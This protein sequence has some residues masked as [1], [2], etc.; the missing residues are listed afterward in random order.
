MHSHAHGG[1]CDHHG[2]PRT[3]AEGTAGGGTVDRARERRRLILTLG[4]TIVI[5]VAEILG[6]LWSHSLALLSDAGHMLSDV[7]AQ[8]L[9]LGA[10]Y[11]AARPADERRTYGWYRIEILAALMNGVALVA[12]SA[13]ILWV[14]AH[15]LPTPVEVQTAL[16]IKIAAVGL[17]ANLIGAWL[18]HDLESLNMRGAY[19]HIL[20]DSL[21]S[22][23]VVVGGLIMWRSRG[24]Y[25]LDPVLSLL[26]GVFVLYSAYR[27]IREAVDVLLEAVPRGID[28]AG[29]THA[30]DHIEGVSGVHD[31]HIWTITSG[32][33]A[34]SAH[35]VVTP[36]HTA[37]HDQLLNRVKEMLLRDF[38]IAHTTLQ[39]ESE[40][41]EH[42]GHVC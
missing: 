37:E 36:G 32:L 17:V 6:G 41:Y 34:L 1:G 39:I 42:V 8:G 18:L 38:A 16:M 28:L 27:L 4:V 23:A 33:H 2:S 26:I 13:G 10:L 7:V 21:S 15:R 22:A 19:L 29:V 3:S 30:I 25:W 24:L 12:L 9:S 31:L 40:D 14:A 35:L 11:L 5:M 20:L